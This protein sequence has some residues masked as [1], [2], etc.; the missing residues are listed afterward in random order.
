MCEWRSY[1]S[2]GAAFRPRGSVY[3]NF[4]RLDEIFG[5]E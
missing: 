4:L 5:S 2:L 1:A 3:E